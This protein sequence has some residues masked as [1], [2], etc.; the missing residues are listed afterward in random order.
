MSVF[1]S[2]PG[3]LAEVGLEQAPLGAR[4]SARAALA[5]GA[6]VS[7]VRSSGEAYTPATRSANGAMRSA[8]ASAC[9]RP[10]SERCRPLARPGRTAPVVG[11]W[12]WR[13]SSTQGVP[14]RGGLLRTSG[15]CK[16][17]N[18]PSAGRGRTALATGGRRGGRL[19]GV[20]A[21][22][23]VAGA[24]GD[25]EGGPLPRL[26]LLGPWRPR[27]RRSCRPPRR[28]RAGAR[29]PTAPTGPAGCSPATAPATSST[30]PCTA[31]ATPTSRRRCTVGDGLRLTGAFI[32]AAVKCAPPANKP[33]PAERDRCRPFLEREL[34]LLAERAGAARPRPVR[35]GR[36]VLVARRAAPAEVRPRRRGRRSPAVGCCSAATT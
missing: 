1:S 20:P 7:R 27:L 16:P 6:A 5:I 33:T 32:T 8:T 18:L 23:A 21:P 31:A 25:G 19:P 24:G 30:P 34:A 36:G 26:G 12:P 9:S 29:P 22:R 17:V 35:V 14:G 2:A 10:L 3:P 13:T 4:P 28:R 15:P 11:V